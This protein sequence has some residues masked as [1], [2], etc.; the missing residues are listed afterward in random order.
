MDISEWLQENYPRVWNKW[1]SVT[2]FDGDVEDWMCEDDELFE[3][4]LEYVE[5]ENDSQ[6]N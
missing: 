2:S 6:S 3:L 5:D 1:L 4:Y